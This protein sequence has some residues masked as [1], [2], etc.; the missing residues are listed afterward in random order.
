ML[1]TAAGD[2]LAASPMSDLVEVVPARAM[3]RRMLGDV[4]HPAMVVRIGVPGRA[5]PAPV[6]PRR[7]SVAAVEVVAEPVAV[8]DVDDDGGDGNRA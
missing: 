5:E 8:V 3:L 1:L 2:G 7:P 4:G 6:S